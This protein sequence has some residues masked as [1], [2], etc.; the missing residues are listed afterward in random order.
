MLKS[1]LHICR[2]SSWTQL[3]AAAYMM[4][5]EWPLACLAIASYFET[6]PQH[7]FSITNTNKNT[8]ISSILYVSF[9]VKDPKSWSTKYTNTQTAWHWHGME[10]HNEKGQLHM[11]SIIYSMYVAFLLQDL[12]SCTCENIEIC[13]HTIGHG[14]KECKKLLKKWPRNTNYAC[15]QVGGSHRSNGKIGKAWYD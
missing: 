5:P 2:R 1:F 4:K 15:W 9:L 6:R 7:M 11:F 10:S 14:D 12:K 8:Q 13:N 3:A